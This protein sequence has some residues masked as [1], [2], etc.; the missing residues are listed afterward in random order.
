MGQ[1]AHAGET[2]G[3]DLVNVLIQSDGC[4]PRRW[5]DLREGRSGCTDGAYPRSDN[6]NGRIPIGT[7]RPAPLC[8]GGPDGDA[9]PVSRKRAGRG[10]SST[11][12]LTTSQ[13]EGT[14]CHSSMRMGSVPRV[15]RWGAP[16]PSAAVHHRRAGTP[17]PPGS[18]RLLSFRRPSG[19]HADCR[20]PGHQFVEL[21]VNDTPT[22]ATR[23][24]WR[25][26]H[27]V[28]IQFGRLVN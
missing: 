6:V 26:R 22:I 19:L 8:V 5:V 28:T 24:D 14:R 12:R 7:I 25:D 27:A 16:Q 9:E 4:V 15:N 21:L 23:G 18:E 13:L 10:S 2:A 11:A 20:E 17:S 1:S 3:D